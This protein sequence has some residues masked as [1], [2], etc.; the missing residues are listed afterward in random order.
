MNRTFGLAGS[1]AARP[2]AGASRGTANSSPARQ[3]RRVMGSSDGSWSSGREAAPVPLFVWIVRQMEHLWRRSGS[4]S[5]GIS[6]S[7]V[8]ARGDSKGDELAQVANAVS[9]PGFLLGDGG[10]DR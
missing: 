8:S 2:V 4:A 7:A 6:W 3:E 1:S 5:T 9:R 10:G